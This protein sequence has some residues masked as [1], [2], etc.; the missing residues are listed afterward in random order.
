M[1]KITLSLLFFLSVSILFAQEKKVTDVTKMDRFVSKTGH[2]IKF[3]DYNLPNLKSSYT[4]LDAKIRVIESTGG[5]GYFY[6]ISMKSKYNDKI[7]SVAED[8]LNEIIK[9]LETLKINAD[10]DK[11]LNVDYLENKFVTDDGFKVGYYAEKN[12]IV[13]FIDLEKY[14]SDDTAFFG[15]ISVIENSFLSAKRKIGELK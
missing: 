13:W 4:L 1:R 6:I 7:A 2:I 14:G 12:K 15:D 5:K 3:I 11:N 8:D 10:K 9:A